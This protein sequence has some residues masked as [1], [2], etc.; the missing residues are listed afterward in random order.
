MLFFSSFFPFSYFLL[1]IVIQEMKQ[2]SFKAGTIKPLG[3]WQL[4][5]EV[6]WSQICLGPR[7]TSVKYDAG[8]HKINRQVDA[9]VLQGAASA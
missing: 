7:R 4:L 6:L 3:C 1:L 5:R 9:V 2:A 8:L